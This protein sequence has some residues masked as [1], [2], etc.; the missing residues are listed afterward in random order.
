MNRGGAGDLDVSQ[1]ASAEPVKLVTLAAAS[2]PFALRVEHPLAG[3]AEPLQS[4][5]MPGWPPAAWSRR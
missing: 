2:Q 4:F 3:I 1:D 5:A